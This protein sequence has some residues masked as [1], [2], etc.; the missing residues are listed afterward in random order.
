MHPPEEML[1]LRW[2]IQGRVSSLSQK[3]NTSTGK[4]LSDLKEEAEDRDGRVVKIYDLTES[5]ASMDRESLE[6]IAELAEE[7]KFDVLGVWKLDRLSRASPWETIRYLNRLRK[8]GVILYADTHGY[9]EWDDLYDFEML[10]R[11]VVFA[12]EWYQRIIEGG[13]E[14][15]LADLE[16]GKWPF[17]TPAYGYETDED[18]KLQLTEKGEKINRE[19]V[20]LYLELE[21]A[22]EVEREIN[23]R[24]DDGPS[25]PQVRNILRNP[26]LMGHLTLENR[27]VRKDDDLRIIDRETF[28]QI[29]EIREENS[30]S[31]SDTKDI[32]EFVDRAANRFGIQ[33]VLEIIDSIG[34]QCRKCGSDTKSNGTTERWGTTVRKYA[35]TDDDCGYE[36]PLL[37]QAEFNDLHQTLP[38]R[39]PYC[40]G[41][42]QFQIEERDGG[43]WKYKYE[44]EMCGKSMGSD[45]P[46]NKI[47]RAM[48]NP[49]LALKWDE[50]T[51]LSTSDEEQKEAESTNTEEA[52][53]SQTTLCTY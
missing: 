51:D 22:A 42:E 13:R 9:F 32:P 27:I 37:K 33:F 3:D 46:P 19:I 18:K 8:A 47:K 23:D 6:E 21:N 30:S 36:G 14:G 35:C 43:Y 7:D 41:T 4:Q 16:Q 52:D 11:R 5:A 24:Y 38:L 17:G 50:K 48:E 25:E 45:M 39:C 31:P 40:P 15:Q 29:Q 10:A 1:G 49:K 20:Q 28:D 2:I 12:R 26:L 53:S 34:T 44:C